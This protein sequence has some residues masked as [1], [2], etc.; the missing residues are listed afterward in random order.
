[1]YAEPR[2][3]TNLDECYF[4]HTMDLPGFGTVPG[5]WDLRDGIAEYL[6]HTAFRG[7]RVLDVGAANGALTFHMEQAGAEVVS[8]DLDEH[9][10][11]DMVPFATWKDYDHIAA[12]RKTIIR[13]LNNAY[14]LAHRLLASR[15]RV[16]YG[17]VYH[18]P[19]AIGPV[20]IAVYGS[21]LL[22][23]R[24]PFLALQNGARLAR[25]AVIV[26]EV[27]RGQ[28]VWSHEP[29]LTFLPDADTLEPKDVWWDVRP[30]AVQRML[31]VLGFGNTVSTCHRQIYEGRV[32]E[33]Y[34]VVG[35]P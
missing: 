10:E 33:A 15:A 14:W 6:G 24:D 13:R 1:M 5:S 19:P 30:E 26:A 35:R 25:E 27:M 2:V 9:G 17:D 8:Y 29:H 31:G 22:H 7:R 28:E 18:I 32:I 16:V 23:L 11:W 12:E 4:Y 34:T 21:I 3:V 20:D